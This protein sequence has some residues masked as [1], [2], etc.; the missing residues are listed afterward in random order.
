MPIDYIT[1]GKG[2]AVG[3]RRAETPAEAPQAQSAPEPPIAAPDAPEPFWKRRKVD[4][5]DSVADEG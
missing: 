1:K 3:I 2:H 5:D 4:T